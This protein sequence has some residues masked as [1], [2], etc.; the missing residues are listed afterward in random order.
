MPCV[1]VNLPFHQIFCG[2]LKK[3]ESGDKF[4]K[5]QKMT[6]AAEVVPPAAKRQRI[7]PFFT[8]KAPSPETEP[9]T[10]L[11]VHNGFLAREDAD[12]IL[13]RCERI[14]DG[15]RELLAQDIPLRG[16]VM[17]RSQG[18]F[19]AD[20]AST[21]RY[22]FSGFSL[23]AH[24]MPDWLNA[25]MTRVE[26]AVE[27]ITGT[28]PGFNAALVNRYAGPDELIGP[29]HDSENGLAKGFVVAALS[30]GTSRT[31]RVRPQ[32][33]DGLLEGAANPRAKYLDVTTQHGQLLMM[34]GENFQR[35]YN[36]AILKGTAGMPATAVRVSITFRRH[37]PNRKGGAK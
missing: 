33:T 14:G 26:A 21:P 16:G 36:H 19:A 20:P 22:T 2:S 37:V 8:L 3:S 9:M 31:F 4:S 25:A 32:T 29:H 35:R 11:R 17:H 13:A 12:A 5:K 27:R 24:P 23:P 30:L 10:G 18:L 1:S 6:T 28:A 34:Y 7:S 15:V